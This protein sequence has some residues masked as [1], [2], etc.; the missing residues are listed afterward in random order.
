MRP[1]SAL[2]AHT[3]PPYKM[4][5]HRETPRALNRPKAARTEGQ[6]RLRAQQ[7]RREDAEEPPAGLQRQQALEVMLLRV[8]QRRVPL[9][10]L[11]VM[12]QLGS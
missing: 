2:R 5:F 8:H 11:P 4:D 12:G 1:L 3:K 9:C 6:Q 10:H 7:R